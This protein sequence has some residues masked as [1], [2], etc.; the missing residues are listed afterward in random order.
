MMR[1]KKSDTVVILTGKYKGQQG[2]VVE[3]LPKKGKI[4]VKDAGIQ[5]RHQKARKQGEV[6]R[7]VRQEGFLDLSNVMPVCPSCK[8]PSRHATRVLEGG[9]KARV[10]KHCNQVI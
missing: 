1:I 10:C 9:E 2:T 8:K 3:I 6:S 7:I 4:K 5:V